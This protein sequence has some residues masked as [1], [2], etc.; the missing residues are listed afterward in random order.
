LLTADIEHLFLHLA[1]QNRLPRLHK[2]LTAPFHLHKAMLERMEAASRAALA[3]QR[4]RIVLKMNALTD[5]VLARALAHASQCGV[6]VEVIV[7]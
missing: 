7:R 5:E 6:Q 1:S 4:A 3:G 2:A